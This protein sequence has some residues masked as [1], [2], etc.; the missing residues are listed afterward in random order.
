MA[1][2]KTSIKSTKKSAKT[3]KH[4]PE[5]IAKLNPQFHAVL[6]KSLAAGAVRG[7]CQWTDNQGGFHCAGGV[8]KDACDN[9]QGQFTP[10]GSC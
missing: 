7:S 1:T 8:T 9:L 10:E 6:T 4:K 2:K 3:A 5:A